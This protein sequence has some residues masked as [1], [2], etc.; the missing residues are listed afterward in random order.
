M[1][2]VFWMNKKQDREG[3]ELTIFVFEQTQHQPHPNLS[4]H[5]VLQRLF[6]EAAL[7]PAYDEFW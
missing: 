6:S 2:L 7:A 5:L 1:E 3:A 4:R